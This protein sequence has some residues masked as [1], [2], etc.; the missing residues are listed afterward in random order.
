MSARKEPI[1]CDKTCRSRAAANSIVLLTKGTNYLSSGFNTEAQKKSAPFSARRNTMD[2]NTLLIIL[3]VLF[4]LG[5][6]GLY[7]RGRWY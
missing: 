2:T 4:V 6:G 5:G 1:E 3:L 7:G